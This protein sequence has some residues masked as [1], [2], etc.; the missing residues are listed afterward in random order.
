MLHFKTWNVSWKNTCSVLNWEGL[1]S[2]LGAGMVS[3]SWHVF[4]D[5]WSGLGARGSQILI[6][7]KR[8]PNPLISSP[9]LDAC[10]FVDSIFTTRPQSTLLSRLP[11][12]WQ[13]H[14][15]KDTVATEWSSMKHC[16]KTSYLQSVYGS[17]W[18]AALQHCQFIYLLCSTGTIPED[19][20]PNVICLHILKD[21]SLLWQN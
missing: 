19:W 7:S 8:L 3:T 15:L 12:P 14:I 20:S 10:A 18:L 13:H 1:S 9:G 6:N 5:I 11:L 21:N 2:V 17:L 4:T 16:R